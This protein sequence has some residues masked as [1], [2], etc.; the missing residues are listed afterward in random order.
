MGHECVFDI[1]RDVAPHPPRGTDASRSHR[2]AVMVQASD[3]ASPI[4]AGLATELAVAD[5][6]GLTSSV[7]ARLDLVNAMV[8]KELFPPGLPHRG[9]PAAGRHQDGAHSP[10]DIHSVASGARRG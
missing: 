2:G 7:I 9:C 3:A 6:L 1:S 8:E 10:V 5:L 4:R